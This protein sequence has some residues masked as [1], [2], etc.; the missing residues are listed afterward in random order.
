MTVV[1]E[2]PII[3][4]PMGPIADGPL[5]QAAGETRAPGRLVPIVGLDCSAYPDIADA[6]RHGSELVWANEWF[7]VWEGQLLL[8]VA[9]DG[10]P[11]VAFG[12]AFDPRAHRDVLEQ[13]RK[14]GGY[15][16]FGAGPLENDPITG[17]LR[18]RVVGMQF[19]VARLR[20]ARRLLGG[21]S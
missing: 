3:L 1:D 19:T 17:V 11:R 21:P 14:T 12:V 4:R 8:S 13:A 6:L 7:G 16:G 2:A 20:A 10:P 18:T 15:I 5:R 9:T